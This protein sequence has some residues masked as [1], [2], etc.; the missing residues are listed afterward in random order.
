[1]RVD[2]ISSAGSDSNFSDFINRLF[3]GVDKLQILCKPC[4]ATKTKEERKK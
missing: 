3:V 4:H 1:M 2:H